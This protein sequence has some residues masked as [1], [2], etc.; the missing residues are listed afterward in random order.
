MKAT[1]LSTPADIRYKYEVVDSMFL[2]FYIMYGINDPTNEHITIK[3][4][5]MGYKYSSFLSIS[6]LSFLSHSLTRI[7]MYML[8]STTYRFPTFVHFLT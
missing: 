5:A 1:A 2:D 6:I 8:F 3:T 4:A 7:L